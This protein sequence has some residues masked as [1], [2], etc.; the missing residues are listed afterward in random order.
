MF[1]TNF[2][3][4]CVKNISIFLS[5][6]VKIIAKTYIF[7]LKNACCK[8]GMPSVKMLIFAS[9]L[10]H[11]AKRKSCIVDSCYHLSGL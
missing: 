2:E 11:S 8:D 6:V 5:K 1:F 7:I 9:N 4:H 3:R 10:S